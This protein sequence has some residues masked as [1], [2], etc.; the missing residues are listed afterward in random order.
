M[1]THVEG[2]IYRDSYKGAIYGDLYSSYI[3]W[4]LLHS[5]QCME[6]HIKVAM[7]GD[8]YRG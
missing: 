2:T 6:T 4:R 7:F 5:V 1:E 3:V 8:V